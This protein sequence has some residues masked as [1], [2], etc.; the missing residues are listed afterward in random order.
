MHNRPWAH[1]LAAAVSLRVSV[2]DGTDTQAASETP[3]TAPSPELLIDCE[4]NRFLR[5][6]LV[7]MLR[8]AEGP[9]PSIR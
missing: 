1:E 9:D 3:K 8:E 2:R 6:V 7:G 5:A 4:E